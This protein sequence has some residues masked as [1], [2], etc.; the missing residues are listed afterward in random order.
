MDLYRGKLYKLS[1]KIPFCEKTLFVTKNKIEYYDLTYE[2]ESD[3]KYYIINNTFALQDVK[4]LVVNPKF[5]GKVQD[6]VTG[7]KFPLASF[8][9]GC[10]KHQSY[11][12]CHFT[13]ANQRLYVELAG[14]MTNEEVKQYYE[15]LSI[16][17][18]QEEIQYM[19]QLIEEQKQYWN[20]IPE[21]KSNRQYVKMIEQMRNS[22]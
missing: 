13:Q 11:Q 1:P 16:Q 15:T 8:T 19:E 20:P 14:K 12:I 9:S 3:N 7:M 10:E 21:K 4:C 17:K 22:K 2:V 18:V 6:I 5:F